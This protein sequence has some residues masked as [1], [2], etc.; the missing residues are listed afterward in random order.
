MKTLDK[1][2]QIAII[3]EAGSTYRN[4]L[5]GLTKQ[6]SDTKACIQAATLAAQGFI[7]MFSKNLTSTWK[8]DP[9]GNVT[10]ENIK[11]GNLSTISA[12]YGG[13]KS[14]TVTLYKWALTQPSVPEFCV[15]QWESNT[16]MKGSK[17][18]GWSSVEPGKGS[19]GN[20]GETLF[21]LK[22]NVSAPDNEIYTAVD[23]KDYKIQSI[24]YNGKQG[25]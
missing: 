20:A 6:S 13:S 9:N 12:T 3:N 10:A 22:V 23:F 2:V 19:F 17:L 4:H 21:E 8:I 11:I 14:M 15:V 25:I 5:L 16:I 7:D 1:E 24:A 18:T